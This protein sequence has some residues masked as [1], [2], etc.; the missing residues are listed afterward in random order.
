MG[1]L[2]LYEFY[3]LYAPSNVTNMS[4]IL[5]QETLLS[6]RS[7]PMVAAL[8]IILTCVAAPLT[9]IVRKFLNKVDPLND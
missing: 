5:L 4:Y 6:E 9:F 1:G 8:G 2:N 3:G 7:Y